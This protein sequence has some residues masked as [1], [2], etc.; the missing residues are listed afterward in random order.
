MAAIPNGQLTIEPI[1]TQTI[2]ASAASPQPPLAVAVVH[3]STS[4]NLLSCGLCGQGIV[5]H[6]EPSPTR[7][8]YLSPANGTQFN[9][10]SSSIFKKSSIT[11]SSAPPSP[12]PYH[13]T[14]SLPA[15]IYIF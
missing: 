11:S 4:A 8:G 10:W 6:S 5:P 9:P 1:A 3:G 7:S 13:D 2:L 14:S 15:Q 12:P